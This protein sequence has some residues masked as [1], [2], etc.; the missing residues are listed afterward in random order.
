MAT[1]SLRELLERYKNSAATAAAGGEPREVWKNKRTGW[2]NAFTYHQ[3]YARPPPVTEVARVTPCEIFAVASDPSGERELVKK[4]GR[5]CFFAWRL[6]DSTRFYRIG[7][8][9]GHEM[10]E[11]FV[12]DR[13]ALVTEVPAPDEPGAKSG[14][15]QTVDGEGVLHATSRWWMKPVFRW[16]QRERKWKICGLQ[17]RPPPPSE[18]EQHPLVRMLLLESRL[19]VSPTQR[20]AVIRRC[21]ELHALSA[22]LRRISR[23]GSSEGVAQRLEEHARRAEA[24]ATSVFAKTPPAWTTTMPQED[25]ASP[26]QIREWREGVERSP[27]VEKW[28]G[29]RVTVA[30]FEDLGFAPPP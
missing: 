25:A 9:D 2:L 6:P 16:Y 18:G 24:R 3:D 20:R 17:M 15:T 1:P 27:E 29:E 30:E 8:S 26:L 12:V 7:V 13:D 23:T 22:R 19:V 11:L 4:L 21:E 10:V 28:I 14:A 5:W